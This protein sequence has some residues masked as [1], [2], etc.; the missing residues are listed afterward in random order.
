MEINS[1]F[2]K[3]MVQ[4]NCQQVTTNSENPLW[5]GNQ[6]VRSEDSSREL[7]GESQ[8]T[9]FNRWRW[10]PKWFWS[11]QGDFICRHHNEPR[12]QLVSR[13]K[14]HSLFHW[15][16]LRLPGATNTNVCV[17][18][19]EGLTIIGKDS[20]SSRY[21]QRNLQRNICGPGE[22][23]TKIQ[24]TKKLDNTRKLRRIY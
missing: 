14:K 4:Q 9:E 23:L 18:R 6:T 22:R 1:F 5:G 19:E 12:V 2:H 15:N 16:T 11:V 21:W 17:T 20:K 3:Q 10:R 8:P 13:R 24:T 7:Q